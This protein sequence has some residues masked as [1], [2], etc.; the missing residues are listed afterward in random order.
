MSNYGAVDEMLNTTENMKHLVANTAHDDDTLVYTGVDWLKINGKTVDHVYVS[1]N[2]WIGLGINSEQLKVCRT[3]AKMWDFYWE[4]ATLFNV[5][6]VLKLRWEGYSRYNSTSDEYRLVYEWLLFETG[7]IMLNLIQTPTLTSYLGTSELNA[8]E[9]YKI[10]VTSGTAEMVS[11]YT[12][13]ESNTQ[14]R[15]EYEM[16]KINPPFDRKY[17][18][19]DKEGKYYRMEYARTIV[20]AVVFNGN[21]RIMTGIFPNQDTKVSAVFNVTTFNDYALFGAR[22][23]TSESKFGVFLSS[24]TE[25]A[26]QYGNTSTKQTTAD[27]TGVDVTVE[28][29]KEGLKRDGTVIYEFST[30]VFESH[31]ELVI[32]TYNTNGA[33]DKTY[34]KG[35]LKSFEVWNG[36]TKQ[37]NLVPCVDENRK[38]CFYDTL[39]ETC[40]YNKGAGRLDYIDTEG[41]YEDAVQMVEIE[42]E[43]LTAEVFKIH[44]FDTI[45]LGNVLKRL[46]NPQILYWQDSDTDLPIIEADITAV[47]PVQVVY[48]QNVLM[49]DETILG[50][51]KMEADADDSTLFAVSF[52]DGKTWKAYVEN[53]WA[54]LSEAS[55]GMTKDTLEAI[56]TDAWAA[57]NENRQYKIRF[58]LMEGGFCKCIKIHYL[59]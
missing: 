48:S 14:Y 53:H 40:F 52:D 45:P 24:A 17:L 26:G 9:T 34:F 44:G 25:L 37:L 12:Q 46:V 5:Y 47:P 32:G 7:D 49:Q 30:Q 38:V 13:D 31:S 43:E 28:L 42:T 21:Q 54:E 8:S 36:E 22:K 11:F 2:S 51:E 33:M 3:D 56:G 23:S 19:T 35:K 15:M 1:G 10:T 27:Y 4:E 29:S 6:R 57:A 39:S 20:D 18:I 50:I 59:N 41:R 16:L 55:S 58:A